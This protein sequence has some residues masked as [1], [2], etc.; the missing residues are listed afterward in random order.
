MNRQTFSILLLALV[1]GCANSDRVLRPEHVTYVPWEEKGKE[2]PLAKDHVV[3]LKCLDK[4]FPGEGSEPVSE[5]NRCLY[6][7]VDERNIFEN[8]GTKP[9]S[10]ELAGVR[11]TY[12]SFL[13]NL[14]EHNCTTFLNRAFASK[15]VLD[16]S[17]GTFN[18]VLTGLSA[19][20]ANAQ[21][22]AAAGL[23]VANLI[24]GKTVDNVNS[25]YY[26]EKT[27][28]ALASSIHAEREERK[29]SVLK[30][31]TEDIRTF[32]IYDALAAVHRYDNACSIRVG[33]EKLQ[34]IAQDAANKNQTILEQT[35]RVKQQEKELTSTKAMIGTL[36]MQLVALA[37]N[38]GDG[39]SRILAASITKL[40]SAKNETARNLAIAEIEG[41]LKT[42][43][44]SIENIGEVAAKLNTAA[45]VPPLAVATSDVPDPVAP[46]R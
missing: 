28:Q 41:I 3:N 6:Y 44:Q 13:M 5:G 8:F 37:K 12:I 1:T 27:F 38:M 45:T 17:A 18:D 26:F 42:H 4:R 39:E 22:H 21:P 29:Q 20:T 19:A 25:T 43:D 32:T 35:E 30:R 34:G 7:A 16:T 31:Y 24:I 15:S 36:T 10:A 11:N 14:S 33:L 46:A 40:K 23:G 2:V 9:A